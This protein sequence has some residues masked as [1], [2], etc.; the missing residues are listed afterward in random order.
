VPTSTLRGVLLAVAVVIGLLMIGQGFQSSTSQAL[1]P[2]SP[3]P[4][5]S[6]SPSVA[7]SPSPSRSPGLTHLQAV[8]GVKIQVL[9]GTTTNGLGAAVAD[10]LQKKGYTVYAVS[11]AGKTDYQTTIIYFES[12]QKSR[13]Q[14]M[15]QHYLNGAEIKPA[16]SLFTAPVQLTVIAGAD[17]APSTT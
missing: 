14:Y 17:Q 15:E 6:P 5:L 16:G 9:N 2:P 13:A 4:S 8:K 1:T 10:D 11:N 3:S 12:G 7:V